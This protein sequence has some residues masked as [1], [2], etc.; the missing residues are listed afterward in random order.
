MCISPGMAHHRYTGTVYM[1][2]PY[3]V[4]M[5][6]MYTSCVCYVIHHVYAMISPMCDVM[7]CVYIPMV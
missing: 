2:I 5:S 3:T 4:Y 6:T 7:V 1:C